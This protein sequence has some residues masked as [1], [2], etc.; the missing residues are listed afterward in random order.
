MT[1]GLATALA[2][3]ARVA[4]AVQ[5]VAPAQVVGS[6]RAAAARA[7]PA[8]DQLQVA[9][10]HLLGARL[11]ADQLQA[12]AVLPLAQWKLARLASANRE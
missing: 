5:V 10:A 6:E 11:A 8:V 2:A 4:L 12:A 3:G 1:M 9:A 7:A